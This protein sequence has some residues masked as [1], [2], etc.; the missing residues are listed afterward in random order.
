MVNGLMW[1]LGCQL[2]GEVVVRLTDLPVPGPVV[3]MAV[4][5][6][7]LVLRRSGDDATVVRAADGLLRH[8]QLLFVPAGVGVVAYVAV[9][10]EDALPI[11]V[12]MLGSWLAGLLAVGWTARLL[13]RDHPAEGA[14]GAAGTV[15]AG[16]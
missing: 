12:A 4:L 3:G 6:A 5:L 1:L 16:P 15:E 10:R 8:L 7:L 14:E 11:T 9:I 13:T 2:V